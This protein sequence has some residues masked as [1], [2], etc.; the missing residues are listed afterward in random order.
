[1]NRQLY[2]GAAYY[3]E[4]WNVRTME[5]DLA[6]MKAV[7]I[8]VVRIGEFLWSKLEPVEDQ[9][10]VSFLTDVVEKLDRNGIA[11]VL[12]TP[13]ATPP[14]WMSDGHPERLHVDADG[15]TMVHGARQHV[16]TNNAYMRERSRIIVTRIAQALGN[17]P[18]IVGWQLDNEFKCH[19]HECFCATCKELWRQWLEQRY[20]K[21][22]NL[23]LQWG[24]QIWS[25]L[26][27]SFD[28][29][30]QPL[31]TPFLHNP[32]LTTAYR[33]FTMERL[34]EYAAEQARI[35]RQYS[36]APITH[37]GSFD[38]LVDNGQLF[39]HLDEAAFDTYAEAINYPDYLM[40][41]D[42]WKTVKPGKSFWLMETSTSHNGNTA[43]FA[44]VHPSG[45]LV[46]EAVAAYAAGSK[47]F[48]YWLWRQQRVG[49][50]ITHGAVLSA[51]GQPTVGYREV[52]TVEQ[53][54][55]QIE[56]VILA[57]V[58]SQ[59]EVAITYS[60]RAK[61]FLLSEP[62]QQLEYQSLMREVYTHVLET[63]IS[64]DLI[65]EGQALDGYKILMTPY[66][67]YLSP[68]YCDRAT[69]FVRQ[70]GIWIVGPLTGC[71]TAEH[72]I[73]TDAGLG[74]LDSLAGVETLYTYP[75]GGS[76]AVGNAFGAQAPLR[77]W[78]AV[79]RC[80]EAKAVGM[81]SGGV[82]SG[83]AF[84]T[85]R[86]LGNGKLVMVGAQFGGK[87]LWRALI[88]HYAAAAGITR[89][90][91]VTPGT[92][93]FPRVG[94]EGEVWFVVNLDGNGGTVTLPRP[95]RKLPDGTLINPGPCKVGRYGYRMIRLE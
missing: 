12:G 94:P 48:I 26:Y 46:A 30:P 27:Q 34:A 49:C 87:E 24:T 66:L 58:P 78:S 70:G 31:R 41:L 39:A 25:Q 28:Q 93:V 65:L 51:W 76:G 40:G 61:A 55:R 19:V 8:N 80:R 23:N 89:R 95:G 53:T 63:G 9:I 43:G 7:G 3:P 17:H 33:L 74:A 62:H 79:F 35:I 86:Q 37:N 10:E 13:T 56:P 4:L 77:G 6:A 83:L 91:A 71:R 36:A 11:T 21:V 84:I 5:Q 50:E 2:H 88:N 90:M 52:L 16:C 73:P 67:P 92:I 59:A 29:I 20:G 75:L 82:T 57:T 18:G 15:R 44:T 72:T 45:Y 32:S 81:I 60:D 69:Q 22:E 14:I 38:F 85:E 47:S 64:R 42:F 54:R 1:M 68:E